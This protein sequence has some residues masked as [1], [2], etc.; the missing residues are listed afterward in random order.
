MCAC[1]HHLKTGEKLVSKQ[2][3]KII[4]INPCCHTRGN[5]VY[6]SRERELEKLGFGL[7]DYA[8]AVLAAVPGCCRPQ[9]SGPG[10]T[11]FFASTL[12]PFDMSC[13]IATPLSYY[14]CGENHITIRILVT[15]SIQGVDRDG[16][17]PWSGP[18]PDSTSIL[19]PPP[20]LIIYLPNPFHCW[21]KATLQ[22]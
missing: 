12:T 7:R 6:T 5:S 8:P 4:R 2:L 21:E 19:A 22:R 17:R 15:L 9:F 18:Q 13:H 10:I 1:A 3:M 20:R 16:E 11:R 14:S